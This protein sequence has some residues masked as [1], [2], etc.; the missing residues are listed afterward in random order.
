VKKRVTGGTPEANVEKTP[1]KS[2]CEKSVSDKLD[3]EKLDTEKSDSETDIKK[4]VVLIKKRVMGGTPEANVKKNP[5]KSDSGKSD[6][7]KTDSGKTDSGKTDSGKTDKVLLK[8]RVEGR[9]LEVPK[10]KRV[11]KMPVQSEVENDAPE[12]NTNID[13]IKNLNREVVLNDYKTKETINL[14]GFLNGNVNNGSEYIYENQKADAE[15]IIEKFKNSEIRVVS[16][17]KKT[18]VGMD[19][20]MIEIAKL[21]TTDPDNDFVISRNNVFFLT[22]MSNVMWETQFAEKVPQCFVKNIFH[23][24]K[25]NLLKEK[26]SSTNIE[27]SLFII[28]EIDS[29]DKEGQQ[30][31]TILE[32][33]NMMDMKVLDEKN[34]RLIFVSA[35]MIN[36]LKNLADWGSKHY[37]H[38]MT[39]PST[40]IGHRDFLEKGIIEEF[41]AVDNKESA[42][43]WVDDDIREKYGE[44]YRVHI[45]RIDDSN[46]K[47]VK[48]ACEYRDI[49]FVQHNCESRIQNS[50]L[51]KIFTDENPRRHVVLAIKGFYRRANLIPNKWKLRIGATHERYTTSCDTNV[52]VQGLPG[53][54]SGYWRNE[55]E[56]GHITGPYRTS[57]DAIEQYENFYE[58]PF[59]TC[60][61]YDTSY[62]SKN[63]FLKVGNM[64]NIKRTRQFGTPLIIPITDNRIIDVK[65]E[66]VKLRYIKE[67][68]Q[69]I[70]NVATFINNENTKFMKLNIPKTDTDYKELV[71]NMIDAESN[72]LPGEFACPVSRSDYWQVTLDRQNKNIIILTSTFPIST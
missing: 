36:E 68:L 20:L 2:D 46:M 65:T 56:N 47:Y 50:I 5:E 16:I 32:S 63:T 38:K 70:N 58:S 13:K 49:E 8:K 4:S 27:N 72:Q 60:L 24:G 52:Q 42:L 10:A 53:R 31:H 66:V 67:M 57:V 19:G 40:Y 3:S 12:N 17:L 61:H 71:S 1:E 41:F 54:M 43:R 62:Q 18:K 22:G 11:K 55:I 34:I 14:E 48:L 51:D 30:L 29:G 7:G 69:K 37:T 9:T 6:S 59:D 26:L 64:K 33:K 44:D 25:F 15:K 23:H 35:T 45:I 39:I 28:D 21:I